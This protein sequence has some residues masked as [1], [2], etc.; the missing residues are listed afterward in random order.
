VLARELFTNLGEHETAGHIPDEMI[1]RHGQIM[2]WFEDRDDPADDHRHTSQLVGLFPGH[3]N[4]V[5]RTPDLAAAAARTLEMRGPGAQGW[6]ILWRACLWARLRDGDRAWELLQRL[7]VPCPVEPAFGPVGGRYPNSFLAH[8]PFQIDANLGLPAAVVEL[9]MQSHNGYVHLLPALPTA[10]PDG[11]LRGVVARGG[12][13]IDMRWRDGHVVDLEITEGF[14][15]LR[16]RIGD[17][18]AP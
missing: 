12:H 8:P 17:E 1:G 2:E 3:S 4:D 11:E 6:A 18:P 13:V 7:N 10:V 15:P 5:E 14:A 9:F 16:V